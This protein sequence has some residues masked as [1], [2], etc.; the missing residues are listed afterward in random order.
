MIKKIFLISLLIIISIFLIVEFIILIDYRKNV[1]LNNKNIIRNYEKQYEAVIYQYRMLS[2]LYFDELINN[3]NVINIIDKANGAS[4]EKK[5]ELRQ[6]LFNIMDEIYSSIKKNNFRQFHF[7]LKDST[8]FLRMHKVDKFGDNLRDVRYTLK[9]ISDKNEYIEGFEEGKVFN[10]YRFE[11]PLFIGDNYIGGVEVSITFSSVVNSIDY[12][13]DNLTLFIIKKEIVKRKV[14]ENLI[15]ENYFESEISDFYYYDKKVYNYNTNKKE[16]DFLSDINKKIK[17]DI[18]KYIDKDE[19]FI[20]NSNYN[21]QM[22]SVVFLKIDNVIDKHAGYIVIYS[23]NNVFANFRKNFYIEIMIILFIMI[24]LVFILYIIYLTKKKRNKLIY[25]DQLTGALNRNKFYEHSRNEIELFNRYKINFSIIMYD[26]DCFKKINDS[27]GHM[28]GDLVLKEITNNVRD[29]IRITDSLFRFGGDEFIVL[30]SNTE[31]E[32]AYLVAEN[33]RLRIE[34]A[35]FASGKITGITIS[36]GVAQ[37]LVDEKCEELM[38]RVDKM[39]YYAKEN[40]KNQ[41]FY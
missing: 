31:L 8:S 30:L 33:I 10:G 1:E 41:V 26:I 11:Y 4:I 38:N 39:L 13:F 25:F 37:Y 21:N 20:I 28:M 40:G 9:Y 22:Y 36:S 15:D 17:K 23:K 2:K 34:K 16:H 18:D 12:L 35:E 3:E 6:K 29:N 14:W 32:N 7:V 19:T 5:A 27:Y 24:A